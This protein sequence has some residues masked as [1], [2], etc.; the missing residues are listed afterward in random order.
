[1]K[2][3]FAVAFKVGEK[4]NLGGFCLGFLWRLGVGGKKRDE[5]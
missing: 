2:T 5:N 4:I 1:M 3:V